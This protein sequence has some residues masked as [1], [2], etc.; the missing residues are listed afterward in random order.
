VFAEDV[1]QAPTA[2][3][4]VRCIG[5]ELVEEDAVL[6]VGEGTWSTGSPRWTRPRL[7]EAQACG[8]DV[9]ADFRPPCSAGRPG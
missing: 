7:P 3:L 4:A 1:E 5:L 2:L 6:D 8:L 9:T